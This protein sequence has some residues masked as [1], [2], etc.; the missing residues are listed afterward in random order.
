MVVE[1]KIDYARCTSCKKC[2]EACTFSVLEWFEDRPTVVN[3]SN[4]SA[5]LECE[6]SCPADAINVKEK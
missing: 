5:C 4:C 1:I 2:I 3:P 6:S